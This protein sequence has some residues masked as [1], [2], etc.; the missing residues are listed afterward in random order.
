MFTVGKRFCTVVCQ[1]FAP[2]MY[3]AVRNTQLTSYLSNGLPADLHEQDC[4]RFNSRV[5]VFCTFCMDLGL[6][7]EESILSFHHST[8]VGE[9]HPQIW[10]K[11]SLFKSLYR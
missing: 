3:R 7:V 5:D 1:F 11:I 9:P 8:E 10:A 6:P 2:L 4:L